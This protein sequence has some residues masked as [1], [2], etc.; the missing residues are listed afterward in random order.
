MVYSL[1]KK[2]RKSQKWIKPILK[3]IRYAIGKIFYQT[4]MKKY[5]SIA[6]SKSDKKMYWKSLSTM[7]FFSYEGEF[8][9]KL[10]QNKFD[11]VLFY[12]K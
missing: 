11:Y 5:N 10:K 6:K 12:I 3:Q 7:C 2:R 8:N 4:C 1:K 9:I